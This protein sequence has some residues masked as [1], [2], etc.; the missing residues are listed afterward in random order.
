MTPAE[1]RAEEYRHDA[2][3]GHRVRQSSRAN[4]W[5]GFPVSAQHSF[6]LKLPAS[7]GNQF[8]AD[9]FSIRHR[10]AQAPRVPPATARLE[11]A[12]RLRRRTRLRFAHPG[13]AA[14]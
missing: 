7:I 5:N 4:P 2:T 6:H 8:E 3:P 14:D 1:G 13:N 9:Q 11:C 10:V 12:L